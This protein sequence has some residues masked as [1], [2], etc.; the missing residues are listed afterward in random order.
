MQRPG[1]TARAE[2]ITRDNPARRANRRIYARERLVLRVPRGL[3]AVT[4]LL[5]PLWQPDF[6]HG[7]R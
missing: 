6:L 2:A 7:H 3:P 4:E 1:E 5:D